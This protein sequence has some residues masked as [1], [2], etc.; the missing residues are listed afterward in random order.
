MLDCLKSLRCTR[1][2]ERTMECAPTRLSYTIPI[3]IK[4]VWELLIISTT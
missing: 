1:I 3:E 4:G 2:G